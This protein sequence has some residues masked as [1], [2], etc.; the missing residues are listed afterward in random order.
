MNTNTSVTSTAAT[1]AR[2]VVSIH[3]LALLVHMCAA[4]TFVGGVGAAYL[5]HA[6]LAWVVFGLGV[7]QALAVLN[8]TLPRLHRLYAVFAILVVIGETLQLFLIPRGHL[9]YHV[10]VA[11]IVW[12]CT[13]ALY[14]RLRD[15]AWGTATAG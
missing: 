10:S 5:T 3:V 7:L 8:P 4:I 6:K 1:V 15:P 11:M 13:L 12:G 14:V 9:A 2:W